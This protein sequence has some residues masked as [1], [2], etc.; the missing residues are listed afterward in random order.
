MKHILKSSFIKRFYAGFCIYYHYYYFFESIFIWITIPLFGL[1]CFIY[2]SYK[3]SFCLLFF[4]FFQSFLNFPFNW[5][6]NMPC[7]CTGFSS[8]CKRTLQKVLC[9]FFPFLITFH[10]FFLCQSPMKSNYVCCVFH[11][12]VYIISF[13]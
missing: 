7:K 2:T 1:Y 10:K 6:L 12:S 4:V 11:Y 3:V 5:H 13:T 8:N 9:W